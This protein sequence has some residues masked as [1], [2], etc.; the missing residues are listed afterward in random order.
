MATPRYRLFCSRLSVSVALVRGASV[1]TLLSGPAGALVVVEHAVRPR[2]YGL[3]GTVVD[4]L[5]DVV[6]VVK[7]SCMSSHIVPIN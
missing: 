7:V 5:P 1:V 2:L 6:G 4:L 3:V